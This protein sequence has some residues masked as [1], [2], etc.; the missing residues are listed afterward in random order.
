M[1]KKITKSEAAAALGR[2]GG[3]SRSAAKVAAARMNG[4]RNRGRDQKPDTNITAPTFQYLTE[5]TDPDKV[6]KMQNDR[7]RGQW[8][9][10]Q[11]LAEKAFIRRIRD[12]T[13]G[14]IPG[15][16]VQ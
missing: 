15:T 9:R 1:K 16:V 7:N 4:A 5:G 2:I 3:R 14:L 12:S 8:K 11:E 13:P 6:Q 10:Q